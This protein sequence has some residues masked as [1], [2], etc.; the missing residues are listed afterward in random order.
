MDGGLGKE[1]WLPTPLEVALGPRRQPGS[2]LEVADAYE[3]FPQ[4]TSQ[5][6]WKVHLNRPSP[7]L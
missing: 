5:G 4:V 3:V 7:S 2:S 6:T 1:R